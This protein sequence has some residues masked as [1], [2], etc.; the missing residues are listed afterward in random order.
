M[1]VAL[2]TGYSFYMRIYDSILTFQSVTGYPQQKVISVT[3]LILGDL[4]RKLVDQYLRVAF[5]KGVPPLFI[6]LKSLYSDP[7][8]V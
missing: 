5:Q 8:K 1:K 2:W 7:N 3:F 6:T 4:F